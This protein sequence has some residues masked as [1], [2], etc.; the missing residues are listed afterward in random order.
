MSR[1]VQR[2]LVIHDASKK[3]CTKTVKWALHL[4]SL[5]PGDKIKFLG[6]VQALRPANTLPFMGCALLSGNKSRLHSSATIK[7]KQEVVEKERRNK[8]DEYQNNAEMKELIQ[9]YEMQQIELEPAVE[10]GHSLKEVTIQ[11]AKNLEATCVILDRQMKKD[12]KYL[13]ENLTCGIL[14]MR[15]DC[16]TEH[17]REPQAV[18]TD[19]DR[20]QSSHTI[21]E[22]ISHE[23]KTT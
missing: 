12:Q 2:V 8:L 16:S 3:L 23:G 1:E 19:I 21:L 6:V 17:L 14:R 22:G 20:G 5:K 11:A 10:A 18:E 15:H 13:M 4:L 9:M 7:K